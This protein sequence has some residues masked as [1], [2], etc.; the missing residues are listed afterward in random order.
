MRGSLLPTVRYDSPPLFG[1]LECVSC[2]V[3]VV[4]GQRSD[5][6]DVRGRRAVGVD[7]QLREERSHLG[8]VDVGVGWSCRVDDARRSSVAWPGDHV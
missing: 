8:D 7:V 4:V 1:R 5:V 3:Y 6:G 2:I